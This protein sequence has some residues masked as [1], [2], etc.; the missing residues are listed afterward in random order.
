MVLF[1]CKRKK[2]TCERKEHR[3]GELEKN[4]S[5]SDAIET[6][7][8]RKREGNRTKNERSSRESRNERE[9][10]R[11]RMVHMRVEMIEKEERRTSCRWSAG[12]WCEIIAREFV[13]RRKKRKKVLI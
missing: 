12:H 4:V 2:R 6:R 5:R 8:A 13:R 9:R 1:G 7:A 11:A 3:V 10:E